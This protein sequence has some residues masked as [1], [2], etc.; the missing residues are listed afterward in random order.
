MLNEENAL[1]NGDATSNA[2]P[3][4]DGTTPLSY[5][6]LNNQVTVANGT[7]AGQVLTGVGALTLGT[8]DSLLTALW[9]QGAQGYYMVMNGQEIQSLVHLLMAAGTIVRYNAT[10]EGHAVLSA[11]VSGYVHPITGELVPIIPSRFQPAGTILFMSER[12]P[13]GSPTADV[14]VLPQVQL[15]QLAPNTNVQGYVAQELAP[16]LTAPQN[17][18]FLVSVYSTLRL[19]SAL[20]VAKAAGVTAVA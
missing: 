9:K 15:P 10:V 5:N 17:Y 4:G 20:H 3:W 6:G 2:A 8:I 12:L 7:P 19:K 16:S 1:L 18:P 11:W 14:S 13:D